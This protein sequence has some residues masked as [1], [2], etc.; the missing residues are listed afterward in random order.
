MP[1]RIF[2]LFPLVYLFLLLLHL[3]QGTLSRKAHIFLLLSDVEIDLLSGY[4]QLLFQ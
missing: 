2:G 4:L 1:E 3:Q